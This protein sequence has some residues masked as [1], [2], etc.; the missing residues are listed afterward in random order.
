[1]INTKNIQSMKIIFVLFLIVLPWSLIDTD[2]SAEQILVRYHFR[3][4]S[5]K[6]LTILKSDIH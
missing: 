6:I 1:M 2:K 4:L 5:L 3:R